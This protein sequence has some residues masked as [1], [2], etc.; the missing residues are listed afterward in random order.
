MAAI[1]ADDIS[2]SIFLNQKAYILIQ[3]SLFQ[4]I[5]LTISLLVPVMA[6][7]RTQTAVKVEPNV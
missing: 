2:K 7:C 3:I 1:F 4:N 5:K 6:W